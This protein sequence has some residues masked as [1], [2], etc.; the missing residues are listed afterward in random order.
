MA[1]TDRA[2]DSADRERD[3]TKRKLSFVAVH[4][5]PSDLALVLDY[6][7]QFYAPAL[8]G[9]KLLPKGDKLAKSKTI[10]VQSISSLSAIPQLALEILEKCKFIPPSRTNE[11]ELQLRVL[12]ARNPTVFAVQG[13]DSSR[14]ALPKSPVG[15]DI[16]AYDPTTSGGAALGG[17]AAYVTSSSSLSGSALLASATPDPAR[18]DSQRPMSTTSPNRPRDSVTPPHPPSTSHEPLDFSPTSTPPRRPTLSRPASASP[19]RSTSANRTRMPNAMLESESESGSPSVPTLRS[20]PSAPSPAP[21][22]QSSSTS[23]SATRTLDSPPRPL[24]FTHPSSSTSS[25]FPST[26]TRTSRSGSVHWASPSSQSAPTPPSPATQTPKAS[27]PRPRSDRD[28]R[29]AGYSEDPRSLI[30]E[31]DDSSLPVSLDRVPEYIELLYEDMPDKVAATRCLARLAAHPPNLAVLGANESLLSALSRVLRD[32]SR[33]SIDLATHIAVFFF[34]LSLY[35]TYHH[36]VTSNKIGDAC[37]KLIEAE[38]KR[39]EVWEQEGKE[40]RRR[41]GREGEVEERRY[42]AMVAKQDKLLFACFHLLLN[43]SSA[44]PTLEHK[45]VRRSILSHLLHCFRRS[46]PGDL[47][48]LIVTYLKRLSCWKEN[49][50]EWERIVSEE[51]WEDGEKAGGRTVWWSVVDAIEMGDHTLLSQLLRLL[52]NLSHRTSLRVSLLRPCREW[53]I[54]TTLAKPILSPHPAIHIPALRTL[55]LFT[56]EDRHRRNPAMD[57]VVAVLAR[58]VIEYP[59]DRVPP[60][61]AAAAVNLAHNARLAKLFGTPMGAFRAIMQ[62]AVKTRDPL[63]LKLSRTL[64]VLPEHK[65]AGLELVDDLT[66][67]V[68]RCFDAGDA[69]RGAEAAGLLAEVG[70]DGMDWA[71]IAKKYTLVERIDTF[72]IEAAR[73][74]EEPAMASGH[75]IGADQVPQGLTPNDDWLLEVIVLLGTMAQADAT[76]ANMVVE[77]GLVKHLVEVMVAKEE[78]DEIIL[79][80][81][82]AMG[83]VWRWGEVESL[84]QGGAEFVAYLIDLL[85]DRNPEIRQLC[86]TCLDIITELSPEWGPRIRYQRFRWHNAEWF[87]VALPNHH[88][89]G[90]ESVISRHDGSG[91]QESY[92]Y[93]PEVEFHGKRSVNRQLERSG[94]LSRL[95]DDDDESE[96]SDNEYENGNLRDRRALLD[97]EDMEP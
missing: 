19:N 43:L 7:V 53:S 12:Y 31:D 83:G 15:L 1:G 49:V 40:V 39:S 67:L 17:S 26:P 33:R 60:E 68:V 27:A 56:V 81:I 30:A 82:Y 71:R 48:T 16:Q 57:A 55:Y 3:G 24:P 41:G 5:H 62:R 23:L 34:H 35:P 97:L 93:V 78:D 54:L 88:A 96:N 28:S 95:S 65:V 79:Q 86:D 77:V 45:I 36:L 63:L 70:A 46:R 25:S 8:P 64:A 69:E 75:G 2:S 66:A 80:V 59:S 38:R 22:H 58:L 6:S 61:L 21:P 84:E 52:S 18:P 4:V 91:T 89:V 47:Q 74:A 11:I 92:G 76:V 73:S 51:E 94:G 20:S 9:S 37:V 87:L 50:E 29:T 14:P 44:S 72:L 10:R 85:Y 42:R 32:D 90:S 13:T